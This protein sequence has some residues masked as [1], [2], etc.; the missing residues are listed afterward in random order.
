MATMSRL[1]ARFS[2]RDP[3]WERH[4][5]PWSAITRLPVLPLLALSVHGRV[6]IGWWC[7]VP[8]ALLLVWAWLNPR[9]FPPPAR[10]DNWF[11][12]ATFGE[13]V[14][15]SS[16]E[17]PVPAHHARAAALLSWAGALALVPVAWGLWVL[18][19]WV[20]GLGV[21]LSVLFRLWMMD[22]M[23]WLHADM[24]RVHSPYAG[25]VR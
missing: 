7:L 11:S 12:R 1:A 13:R 3:V 4:A 20:T 10:T 5:N 17:V 6:W 24:A 18:D 8:V 23:V 25:W 15:L 2:M 9:A 19:P 22:R 21:A 14:W 16:G